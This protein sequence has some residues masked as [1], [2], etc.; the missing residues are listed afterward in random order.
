MKQ[1]ALGCGVNAS[2]PYQEDEEV[3]RFE[4]R[5]ENKFL[6]GE[7]PLARKFP[8]PLRQLFV[9]LLLPFVGDVGDVGDDMN[10]SEE[11]RRTGKAAMLVIMTVV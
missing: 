5:V 10:D 8:P 1:R 7:H 3:R 9:G 4:R 6:Q 2:V 11:E